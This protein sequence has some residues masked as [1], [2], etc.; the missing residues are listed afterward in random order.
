MAHGCKLYEALGRAEQCT[1]R[2]PF[3]EPGGAVLP[4]RCA[5][6]RVDFGGRQNVARELLEIRQRLEREEGPEQGELWRR[7]HH[8]LNEGED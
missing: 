2:C 8:V 3:W 4:G 5:F 6:E 1:G 7:F